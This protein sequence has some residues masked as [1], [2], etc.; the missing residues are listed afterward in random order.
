MLSID[1]AA[2][3]YSLAQEELELISLCIYSD[4]GMRRGTFG[5]VITY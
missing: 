2:L 5:L 4:A 3:L 1:K